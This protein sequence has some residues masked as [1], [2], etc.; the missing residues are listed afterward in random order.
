MFSR[1]M[2]SSLHDF[3]LRNGLKSYVGKDVKETGKR[4][5]VVY[6]T[7]QFDSVGFSILS[8]RAE[9]G[10]KMSLAAKFHRRYLY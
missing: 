7:D 4:Q 10:S 5:L 2:Q 8:F 1:I 9:Q 6:I 3:N